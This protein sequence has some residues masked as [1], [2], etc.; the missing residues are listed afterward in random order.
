MRLTAEDAGVKHY[1]GV[2]GNVPLKVEVR[3]ASPE[4]ISIQYGN[5]VESK[6]LLWKRIVLDSRKSRPEHYANEYQAILRMYENI[7]RGLKVR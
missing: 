4:N 6:V 1:A 3:M 7:S 5:T 2:N